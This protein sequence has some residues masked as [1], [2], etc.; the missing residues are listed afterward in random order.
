MY[1][2]NGDLNLYQPDYDVACGLVI[3]VGAFFESGQLEKVISFGKKAKTMCE[4]LKVQH[5]HLFKK[6]L[7]TLIYCDPAVCFSERKIV[8]LYNSLMKEKRI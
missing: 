8:T 6:L 5:T 1:I 7:F 3:L 4:Q 2:E